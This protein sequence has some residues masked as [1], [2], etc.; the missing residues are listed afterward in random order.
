MKTLPAAVFLLAACAQTPPREPARVVEAGPARDSAEAVR[1]GIE[2]FLADVPPALRGKRVGLITNHSAT[3]R[4]RTPDI[5][6]IARHPE[7]RLV[8]LLA[9][10]H[11]PRHGRSHLLAVPGGGPRPHAGDAPGRGRAGL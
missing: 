10:E 5:D 7:L 2:T 3:D 8:A 11:G 9:P 1:P 6:L 4:A